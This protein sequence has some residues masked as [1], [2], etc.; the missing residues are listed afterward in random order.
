MQ[1]R[2]KPKPDGPIEEESKEGSMQLQTEN[3]KLREEIDQLRRDTTSKQC[4]EELEGEL[5]RLR[6]EFAEYQCNHCQQLEALNEVINQVDLQ[7]CPQ[8]HI[9]LFSS[10]LHSTNMNC[11]PRMK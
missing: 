1:I 10:L 2:I 4:C 3:C 7:H 11:N 5:Q 6:N 9:P 8:T